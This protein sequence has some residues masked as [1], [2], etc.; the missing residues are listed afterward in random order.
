MLLKFKKSGPLQEYHGKGKIHFVDGEEA[1]VPEEKGK[2]L[3]ETFPENFS[4]GS[5]ETDPPGD[6]IPPGGEEKSDATETAGPEK[7]TGAEG[8]EE[9]PN[10]EQAPAPEE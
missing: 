3:L 10:S 1:E 4:E 9:G 7:G 6:T 5:K 8:A 2:Y